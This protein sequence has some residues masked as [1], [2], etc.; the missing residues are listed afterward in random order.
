[1]Q[2]T[3][4]NGRLFREG[5]F[6]RADI[7]VVDGRIAAIS[8]STAPGRAGTDVNEVDL[9]G[10]FVIPGLVDA[11]THLVLSQDAARAEPLSARVLKGVRNAR[12]QLRSGVTSVRDVGGPGRIA[13]ELKEAIRAGMVEGP[14]VDTSGSFVCAPGGHVS[15][16]GREATGE[17]E[18]R[19]AVREQRAAGADFIKIMASGG[20]ADEG[21]DPEA[22]Q[23]EPGE[24]RALVSE[25]ASTG[26]YVAAH[27]H[28]ATAIRLCLEAGVR[29]IEHASFIDERGVELAVERG[30][31]IVPTFI[32]YDVIARS[33]TL[34]GFQRD[35]AARVLEKKAEAFLAAV[36]A[37]VK[38]GAGTDAGTYMPQGQLWQEL[39]FIERLGVPAE[40]VLTAATRTNAEI[41]Q[42]DEIGRLEPGAWADLLVLA[43]DPTADLT[44]LSTPTLVVKGGVVVHRDQNSAPPSAS[45]P[46]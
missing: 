4:R 37:G 38:W 14:R 18:A 30:A 43:A 15:Y 13:V 42:T 32:V 23:F 41:L 40:A 39:L 21:E 29:T 27:A 19:L 11:H 6:Q 17:E 28:P 12:V 3:F 24:L 10:A 35:L 26:T 20:V 22:P 46:A 5:R 1:M 25:A 9:G 45:N 44:T 8:A 16:W 34:G 33:E 2:A 36:A 7:E 31:Y